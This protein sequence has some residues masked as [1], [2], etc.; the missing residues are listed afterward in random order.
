MRDANEV[1]QSMSKWHKMA[2]TKLLLVQIATIIRNKFSSKTEI[3]DK[4]DE[5]GT[6]ITKRIN[7]IKTSGN[8][9]I[10][11]DDF[12]VLQLPKSEM[13]RAPEDLMPARYREILSCMFS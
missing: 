7:S 13:A 9:N 11:Q 5:I 4:L 8:K 10:V 1:I 3:D 2:D 6:L 12:A